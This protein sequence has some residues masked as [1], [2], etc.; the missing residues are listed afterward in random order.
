[1]TQVSKNVELAEDGKEMSFLDH[2]EELR[3]HLIRA[4][5]AIVIS[6]IVVFLA[7]TFVFEQIIFAPKHAEFITYRIFCQ[8]GEFSCFYPPEFQLITRELGEQ[9]FVHIQVSIWLGFILA[10]PFVFWEV[11][12]FVK[13]GLLPKEQTAA[14][15]L[16]LMCSLLFLLGVS[17]GYY[18][19]S[20]FAIAFLAGYQVGVDAIS[21]P[22]LSSYVSNMTMFTIPTGFVFELPI[23]VYFLS[24]V[25]LLSASFMATYRKHAIIIILVV[26]A[27]ITPPDVI[28]QILIGIP[29]L[30][31][32]EISILIAK[33]TE[34]KYYG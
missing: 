24:R 31:L 13:P 32:Y 26:A 33:R 21:S 10:S 27:V 34:K 6:G 28:T 15:G 5:L 3:W 11:W 20:P 7:K 30:V 4:A 1:M 12:R 16:V 19:I 9:F 17:F 14:K 2:L 18:I 29:I 23:L 22:T 25:G 8:L